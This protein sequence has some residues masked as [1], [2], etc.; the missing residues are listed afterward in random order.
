MK[1]NTDYYKNVYMS[2]RASLID[3]NNGDKVEDAVF[4]DCGIAKLALKP[5]VPSPALLI[6]YS[7]LYYPK[8]LGTATDEFPPVSKPIEH[9]IGGANNPNFR[10]LYNP[11]VAMI[12]AGIGAYAELWT[13][14][15]SKIQGTTMIT[16]NM[17]NP[18]V[19][20]THRRVISDNLTFK[21]ARE[22]FIE[23]MMDEQYASIVPLADDYIANASFIAENVASNDEPYPVEAQTLD[24]SKEFAK[25][26]E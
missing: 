11:E 4:V 23:L 2:L 14:H 8:W 17:D 18:L 9:F 1:P 26:H 25:E 6:A 15:Y 3:R 19:K 24:L 21:N 13:L 22:V 16:P 12:A 5:E 20:E 7:M 10:L